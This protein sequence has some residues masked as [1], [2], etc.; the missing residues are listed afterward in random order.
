M[1]SENHLYPLKFIPIVKPKVWGGEKLSKVF[2]K[3]NSEGNI[4]ESWEL[5]GVKGNISIVSNGKFKG[6]NL[7]E[8]LEQ[9][10]PSILGKRVFETYNTEF[11]LL[12]KFIDAKEDLSVQLHPDDTLAAE[13]HN[14]FGKTEMWYIVD[15]DP[16]A[17][18]IVGFN[19]PMDE[20]SYKKVLSEGNITDILQIEDI[21]PGDVYFIA[22]G[23]VHAI[24]G[25]T[26]LAEIQQTSDITYRIYDWDRPDVDGKMRELHTDLALKAI[27]YRDP[28]ARMD[29]DDAENQVVNICTSDYFKT[30]KLN[31]TRAFER[32]TAEIDSFRVY[33]C[34]EGDAQLQTEYHSEVIKKG[35]T[36]LIP[37][38]IDKILIKTNS[39]TLLE[40]YIP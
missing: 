21:T 33:M 1:N 12:F 9:H 15:T 24:G 6:T 5:S 10:G 7:K 26:L 30:N 17:R 36:I 34:I 29:Y 40:V 38:C 25:G 22:P 19:R 3:G 28:N 27:N 35:E 31:L 20:E 8:L 11:P 4:G 32:E 13:R 23:T 16:Q 14:S 18:L 37:A 2:G 39:A